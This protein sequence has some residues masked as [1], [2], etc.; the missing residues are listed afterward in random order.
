MLIRWTPRAFNDLKT[1]S[2][3]IER[4]RNLATANRV[5]RIIHDTIQILRRFRESGTVETLPH[6]LQPGKRDTASTVERDCQSRADYQSAL[7]A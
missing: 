6:A 2:S 7:L 4:Q 5:C 1:I 3:H